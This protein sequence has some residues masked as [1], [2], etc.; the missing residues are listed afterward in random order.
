MRNYWSL[1][2]SK[3]SLFV[4]SI[5]LYHQYSMWA[6]LLT[7]NSLYFPCRK[8]F[9]AANC[10]AVNLIVGMF[11]EAPVALTWSASSIPA[12]YAC[13]TFLRGW[14]A[15][16]CQATGR[17]LNSACVSLTRW[18]YAC[19]EV[20]VPCRLQ[21]KTFPGSNRWHPQSKLAYLAHGFFKSTGGLISCVLGAFSFSFPFPFPFPFALAG[22]QS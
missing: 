8:S 16:F 13:S 22:I 4:L 1:S 14:S 18:V 17:P 3:K 15:A 9:K 10:G 6:F 21:E 19:V 11:K 12:F 20:P 7:S 2:S 5:S